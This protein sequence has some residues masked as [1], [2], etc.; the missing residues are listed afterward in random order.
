VR[1]TSVRAVGLSDWV[2]SF[3]L[4]S[5]AGPPSLTPVKLLVEI[6]RIIG[7]LAPASTW[8]FDGLPSVALV[9]DVASIERPVASV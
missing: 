4:A 8:V 3:E 2:P 6:R 1:D 9:S 7:E 5:T